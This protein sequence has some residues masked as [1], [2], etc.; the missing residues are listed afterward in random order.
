MEIVNPKVREDLAAGRPLAL[1]LGSGGR[2]QPGTYAVDHLPLPGVDVVAD[3]NAPFDL[4][5]DGCVDRIH[6][7]HAFE[8][9][10]EF[11]PLMR[12]I[13]RVLRP[14]GT[15][16][17][18]VPH[19]SNV[20]AYSDPTHVRFFGLYTMF[21]FVA[22]ERQPHRRKVPAFYTDA[23]FTVDSVRIDF[24]RSG[25]LDRLLAP[26]LSRVVNLGFGWQEFY[27]RRLSGAFHAWQIRYVMTPEK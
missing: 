9:V 12:E 4:L 8:H 19:F 27:E 16:E 7:R 24:Y 13:H 26:L 2:A 21:Y 1:D 3:L 14:G 17:I 10:R 18:T 6:S 11:L 5:P 22:P 20:Y 15:A 23:R 25:P